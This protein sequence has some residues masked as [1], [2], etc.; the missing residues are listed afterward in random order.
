M[1]LMG[2]WESLE[3]GDSRPKPQS[4][5]ELTQHPRAAPQCMVPCQTGDFYMSVT[6]LLFFTSSGELMSTSAPET[7]SCV[8]KAC[9]PWSFFASALEEGGGCDCPTLQ[10]CGLSCPSSPALWL[11]SRGSKEEAESAFCGWKCWW[12]SC[13]C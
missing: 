10:F 11:L 1:H 6:E 3:H 8:F 9:T 2:S 12:Q 7:I 13:G 4:C 5:M